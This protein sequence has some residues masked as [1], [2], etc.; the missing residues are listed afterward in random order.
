K[1]DARRKGAA[2]AADGHRG[3]S[4]KSF[5]GAFQIAGKGLAAP[6]WRCLL[7]YQ[8]RP[9]TMSALALR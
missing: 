4:A 6:A 1:S 3:H 5:A 2:A 8:T 7:A 9:R